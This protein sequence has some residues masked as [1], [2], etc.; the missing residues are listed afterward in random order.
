M[1]AAR[2]ETTEE[3]V[4]TALNSLVLSRSHPDIEKLYSILLFR[5]ANGDGITS[6]DL[7][8]CNGKQHDSNIHR[9]CE[10]LDRLR[11][12]SAVKSTPSDFKMPVI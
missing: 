3:E 10:L 6:V 12:I 7:A 8:D 5:L 11:L 4:W 2:T 9:F 1:T